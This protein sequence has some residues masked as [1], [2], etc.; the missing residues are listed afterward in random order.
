MKTLLLSALYAVCISSTIAQLPSN[1]KVINGPELNPAL[2]DVQLNF[3]NP[4]CEYKPSERVRY[5]F[6][7]QVNVTQKGTHSLVR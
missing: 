2:R 6:Y 7:D 3:Q 5:V 4:L 1:V